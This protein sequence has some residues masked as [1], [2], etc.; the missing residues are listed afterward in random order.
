MRKQR[1]ESLIAS[2]QDIENMVQ[3]VIQGVAVYL[4]AVML[5]CGSGMLKINI[6]FGSFR[7]ESIRSKTSILFS[8]IS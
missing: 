7:R 4:Y 6:I 2:T 8:F 1:R 3:E 5:T